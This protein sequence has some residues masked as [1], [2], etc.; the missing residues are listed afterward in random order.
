MQLNAMQDPSAS[1][2]AEGNGGSTHHEDDEVLAALRKQIAARK[3][4]V[5][6]LHAELAGIEPEL[7]RYE[8]ALALLSGEAP[9]RK[10]K[11]ATGGRTRAVASKVST[12]RLELVRAAVLEFC[13]DHDEFRQV[14]IRNA[15]TDPALQKSSVMATAFEQLRQDGVI[16]FARQEG[17]Q[18]WYRLTRE[19]ARELAT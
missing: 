13:A 18:K 1:A 10:S 17:I 16:R 4:R 14:D 7:K 11:Q 5:D 19:T 6:E 3:V 9:T 8:R 12:E 2:H 15:A